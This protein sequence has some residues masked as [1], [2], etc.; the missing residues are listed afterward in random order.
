MADDVQINEPVEEVVEEVVEAPEI[1]QAALDAANAELS[2]E[3]REYIY[4]KKAFVDG[5]LATDQALPDNFSD[6]G[7]YFDS[8]KEAAGQYTQGRQEVREL[9]R[10]LA[11]AEGKTQEEETT[12]VEEANPNDELLVPEPKQEEEPAEDDTE[13]EI[14]E[15]GVDEDTWN[16]WGNEIDTTGELSEDT[17]DNVLNAFPGI[18]REMVDQFVS[19]RAATLKQNFH[20]AAEVVGGQDILNDILT[21]CG[22][23]LP[24]AEREATNQ[25]LQTSARNATLLGLKAQYESATPTTSRTNEPTITAP[26]TVNRASSKDPIQPF[27]TTE[28]LIRAQN[29]PRY[30]TESDYTSWVQQRMAKSTWLYST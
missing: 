4:E 7:A 29:D 2:K 5:S 28:E 6:F 25:A 22:D 14:V 23:N 8:L 11:I 17:I 1:P 27:A 19:G 21:W 13:T 12:E 18:T 9:E 26:G 10:K 3:A 20:T 24:P 16:A 15:V 30:S